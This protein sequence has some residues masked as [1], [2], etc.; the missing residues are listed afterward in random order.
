MSRNRTTKRAYN[1]AAISLPNPKF[2]TKP[3]NSVKLPIPLEEIKVVKKRS[4]EKLLFS[5]RFFDR[6]HKAFNLGGIEASWYV[7]ILDVLK[8]VCQTNRNNLVNVLG[9]KYRAHR[10]CWEDT[11]FKFRLKDAF[12]EQVE[13]LQISASRAKG[14]IHGFI[15]GN[16]FYIV[17]L[18]RHHNLYPEG[19]VRY[20]PNP[21][22]DYEILEERYKQEKKDKEELTILLEEITKPD[23]NDL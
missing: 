20:F 21:K 19:K 23:T 8:E 2:K 7:T 6:N 14:R 13:C 17:W 11:E 10:L 3:S 4:N 18:D 1:S 9:K 16:T 15:V 12:M 5:F 22:T